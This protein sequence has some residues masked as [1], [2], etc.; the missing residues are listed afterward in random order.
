LDRLA[1][2][3]DPSGFVTTIGIDAEH[4]LTATIAHSGG[5]IFDQDRLAFDLKYF[6]D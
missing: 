3:D 5:H 2:S 6:A 1:C 4:W